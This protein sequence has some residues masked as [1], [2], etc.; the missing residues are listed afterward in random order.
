MGKAQPKKAPKKPSAKKASTKKS[1]S[2]AATAISERLDREQAAAA[3]R[4]VAAGQKLTTKEQSA[5]RRYEKQQEEDRRW[6]YYASIPQ[7]HWRQMSGR[8]TKVINEQAVRYGIPFGGASINLPD[9]V[10]GIHDFLAA[11]VL[12]LNQDDELFSDNGASSPALER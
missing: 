4:K 1:T 7:K 10:R 8:Q 2:G 3:I 6:Q 5:L 11:N 12:K 9:V